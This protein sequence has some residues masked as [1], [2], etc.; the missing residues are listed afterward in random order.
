MKNPTRIVSSP[1]P[2]ARPQRGIGC[3]R[4][5]LAASLTLCVVAVLQ[6]VR[7]DTVIYDNDFNNATNN[8]ANN[9]LGIGGGFAAYSRAAFGADTYEQTNYAFIA[10]SFADFNMAALDSI[11][12][13]QLAAGGT[14][15]EFKNV[16]FSTNTPFLNLATGTTDRLLLGITR[17][18]G[19]GNWHNNGTQAFPAG[20]WIQFMSDSIPQGAGTGGWNGTSTLFYKGAGTNLVKLVSWKFDNLT[21]TNAPGARAFDR[22][23]DI[24]VTLTSTGWALNITGDTATN[25][26]ISYSGT[27]AAAGITNDL[28]DGIN[29]S[30]IAAYND[31]CNPPLNMGIDRVTV[32]QLGSIIVTTPRILTPQ[33][34]YFN[35]NTVFA[36]E[37]VTLVS[38]VT[39]PGAATL[40]WQVEDMSTP[41]AFAN[42]PSGNATNADVDTSAYANTVKGFQLV[43]TYGGNSVTSAVVKV[44]VNAASQPVLVQDVTPNLAYVYAGQGM[45]FYAVF[46]GNKPFTYQWQHSIDSDGT[47]FTNV[48]GATN[49]TFVINSATAADGNWYQLVVD[50]SQGEF[51]TYP[52]YVNYVDG[53]PQY[54]WSAVKSF[55]NLNADQILTNFPSN[56]KIAGAMCATNGGLPTV[57]GTSQ[58]NI[59]FA[60]SGVSS[61]AVSANTGFGIGAST[62]LTGNANFDTCLNYYAFD[63]SSGIHT[64]TLSNLIVGKQY[65]VQLF[66]FDDRKDYKNRRA[67]WTDPLNVNQNVSMTYKMGD[68]VYILGTFIASNTVQVIQQNLLTTVG[69]STNNGNFNALVLRSVG[70]NPPP[71]W[72]YL[73]QAQ[74]SLDGRDASILGVAGSDDS[75]GTITYQWKAGPQG[76][77]YTNLVE[78]A[79][80]TGTTSTNLT[81]HQAGFADGGT[82][83][84]YVLAATNSAGGLL[85]AP[86]RLYVQGAPIGIANGSYG[87]LVLSNQPDGFWMLDETND[88]STGFLLAYDSS[89]H[90]KHGLYGSAVKDGFNGIL[91]PQP[92]SYAGF[93]TNQA[94]A[95]LASAL[96]SWV[97]LPSLNFTNLETSYV[98][99]IQPF[100]AGG[101]AQG[102]LYHRN[103]GNSGVGNGTDQIGG[104]G[105]ANGG[106]TLAY[107][108]NDNALTYQFAGGPAP[109][110]NQWQMVALVITATNGTIYQYYINSAGQAV[111]LKGVNNQPN[112]GVVR[113]SGGQTYLGNDS[114]DTGGGR[115]FNGLMAGAAIFNHKLSEA[116]MQQLFATGVGI[117]TNF[118]PSF[119]SQP[120]DTAGFP[121]TTVQF[122]ATASG[123][124]PITNQWTFNGVNLVDG[125]W[126]SAVVTGAKSNVLTIANVTAANI[127]IFNLVL[128][129]SVGFLVSSNA[130]LDI[131][132][133]TLVGEWLP[134]TQTFADVSGFKPAGTHDAFLKSGSTYWTND[135]PPGAL[136]TNSLYFVNGGLQVSN[137]ATGDAGYKNTYDAAINSGITV[138]CW[139]KGWPGQWNPW[140]SKWGE[141]SNGW[142]LRRDAGTNTACWTT[143]NASGGG[144]MSA[145]HFSNDGQWHHYAGTF[146]PV[147]G[148]KL[149]YVDGILVARGAGV[150]L[151]NLGPGAH[152]MIGGR[153]A[154]GT[155]GNYFTGALYDV[156]IYDYPLAQ[157]QVANVSKGLGVVAVKNVYYTPGANA[158]FTNNG[159][160]GLAPFTGYRWQFNNGGGF[161]NLSDGTY[162]GATIS[163]S[164]TVGMT[165]SG[166]TAGNAGL[167]QLLVTNAAGVMTNIIVNVTILPTAMVGHWLSGPQTLTDSSGYAPANTHDAG[168]ILSNAVSSSVAWSSDVPAIAGGSSYSML[169]TNALLVVSNSAVTDAGYVNTFDGK[170][171]DAMTVMVWAKGYQ[172]GWNPWVSKYGENGLSWQLRINNGNPLLPDWTIRATGGTEDMTAASTS[173]DGNWHHYAGTYNKTTGDRSLYVDGVLA[174]RQTGQGPYTL[175]LFSHLVIGGRDNGGNTFNN[176]ANG[177]GNYMLGKIYDVRVYNYGLDQ[178][179][180]RAI[181]G[182]QPLNPILNPIVLNGNQVVLSWTNGTLVSATNVA[183]PYLPVTNSV[184]LLPATSPF[185]NT[186]QSTVPDLFFKVRN[187]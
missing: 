13:I 73:P 92:P 88:P 35:T 134:G 34:G 187:P 143:R 71:Y 16:N 175:N 51:I 171:N 10:T 83:I 5:L 145:T 98:L 27:Y 25:N 7:A 120:S 33:Y 144:D 163:G 116:T 122:R 127:G 102:L 96:R 135:V 26:P 81:I 110:Q 142:Q 157:E 87:A 18:N 28:L 155:F 161:A 158:G 54:L 49:D 65:Q 79:K 95:Q 70:W 86:A 121:N 147:T 47:T 112:T 64:I 53:T 126:G 15:I 21:W 97:T 129:N 89:G 109:I 23:L 170:I 2:Y 100:S 130:S 31:T 174:A 173:N 77:P 84:L 57:V 9:D 113:Y 82:N 167:Y 184:T 104:F 67:N 52:N 59:L 149:L 105:Y 41:G 139:A 133:K 42:L 114:Y 154:N 48:P 12:P 106:T 36:G 131:L 32:T 3:W 166:I 78:G 50:N 181:I 101:Y 14:T 138:M 85:S 44:A 165:V 168:V 124:Q 137:S 60:A 148:I 30:Y 69:Y 164:G 24:K 151:I 29:S 93:Y 22:T 159:I 55:R 39:T 45:S 176:S 99:W 111:L 17:T 136:G 125:A 8:L 1:T 180:V 56:Y 4:R 61:A 115:S 172:A 140:V 169:L 107:N 153:D 132:T 40:Q 162:L 11:N 117:S 183:G 66:G 152:L 128:S 74:G 141:G 6:T 146:D 119:V 46:D 43:A 108:W 63:S 38:S 160:A 182:L 179:S 178:N 150:G 19:P 90:G 75:L 80:Y 156:R 177:F 103:T 123:T 68:D 118:P 94:G 58:G 76:G 186:V 72:A 185:T 37:T 91:S 20:F 62:N